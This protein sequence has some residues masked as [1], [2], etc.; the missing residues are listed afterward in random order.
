MQQTAKVEII[1]WEHML[2]YQQHEDVINFI[3]KNPNRCI[4]LIG[5]EAYPEGHTYF[6]RVSD[7]F[8]TNFG[9]IGLTPE[10][11]KKIKKKGRPSMKKVAGDQWAMLELIHECK[12]QNAR[13]FLLEPTASGIILEELR[14]AASK[15]NAFREKNMAQQIRSV[16][17]NL[18]GEKLL[19]ICGA[20]HACPLKKR[21]AEIGIGSAINTEIF[22]EKNKIQE[23]LRKAEAAVNSGNPKEMDKV[24]RFFSKM[25]WKRRKQSSAQVKKRIIGELQL[26]KRKQ[27]ARVRRKIA[28]SKIRP[29]QQ[30]TIIKKRKEVV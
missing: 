2:Y 1:P 19:A 13:I 23:L 21:L 7:R 24:G 28:R 18:K 11:A 6:Q 8:S 27:I 3:R 20:V 10:E 22:T 15:R 4:A 14:W 9:K 5:I 16:L 12:R 25:K 26:I 30:R 29:W 17:Y